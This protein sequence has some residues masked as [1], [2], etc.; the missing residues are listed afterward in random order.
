MNPLLPA[1]PLR[2]FGRKA[3]ALVALAAAAMMLASCSI[4]RPSPV[5]RTFLL[6]PAMPAKVA[7]ARPMSVRVGAVS[8]AAPFRGKA[9]V[10]RDSDLRYESD[11]YNEFFVTP[12]AMLTEATAKALVAA[13]VFRRVVPFGAAADDGDYV[14]DGF[15][16]ELYGDARDAA[17]PVAVLAMSFYLSPTGVPTPVVIWS[18]EYRQRVPASATTPEALAQAWSAALS[19]ILADLARDLAGAELPSK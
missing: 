4:S 10:Y 17:K 13:N 16:S 18:R 3:F 8:V 19:A 9:F 11:Y 7:V 6:E 5:K 2:T 14:L 15:V 12:A 1:L